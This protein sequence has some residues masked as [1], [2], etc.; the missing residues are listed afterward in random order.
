MADVSIAP[1]APPLT[2][3]EFLIPRWFA[4]GLFEVTPERLEALGIQGLMLDLDNTLAEYYSTDFSPEVS[5]WLC[6]V[7]DVG[8][9]TCVVSNTHR[10]ARLKSLC[11]PCG[12]GYVLGVR[13]PRRKGFRLALAKMGTP[14]ERTAIVGDQIFTDVLGGNRMGLYTILVPPL[15]HKEFFATRWVSRSLERVLFSYLDRCRRTPPRVPDLRA[16]ESDSPVRP[17]NIGP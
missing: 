12:V 4:H 3:V 10:V 2:P 7:H 9:K 13:K 6:A 16:S 1:P 15:S 14:P 11:E 5:E 17:E 8:I